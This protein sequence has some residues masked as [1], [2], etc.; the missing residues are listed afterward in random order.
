MKEGLGEIHIEFSCRLAPRAVRNRRLVFEN[1][2]QSRISAYLVNC[3]VPHDREY[4]DR[5]TESKRDSVVLPI[6]LRAGRRSWPTGCRSSVGGTSAVWF[7]DSPACSASA[8]GTSLKART[9]SCFCS[10]CFLPAP[11]I[12]LGSRWAGF[13][14]VRHSVLQILKVVTAFTVG[15]SITLALAALGVVRVRAA[16]LKC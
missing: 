12:A 2:H 9:I 15:H 3:L 5:C 10:R 7:T 13:A 1:H 16:R 14:G 6:G 4:P 8:C 11:L